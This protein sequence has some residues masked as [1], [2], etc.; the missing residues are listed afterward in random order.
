MMSPLPNDDRLI[1]K[2]AL[3]LAVLIAS[4]HGTDTSSLTAL[5]V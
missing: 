5:V 3:V 2:L 1:L 4:L